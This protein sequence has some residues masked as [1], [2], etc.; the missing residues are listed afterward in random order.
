MPDS[1]RPSVHFR[2]FM[3]WMRIPLSAERESLTNSLR[4]VGLLRCN[5]PP[6]DSELSE[7]QLFQAQCPTILTNLD[8]SRRHTICCSV[9]YEREST[10]SLTCMTPQY[11]EIHCK[12]F[13]HCLATRGRV[14]HHD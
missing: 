12:I 6:L 13:L 14:P 3:P 2:A 7:F 10:Q 5:D 4:M 8:P 1:S 9:S 11:T